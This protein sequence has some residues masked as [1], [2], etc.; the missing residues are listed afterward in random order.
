MENR[1]LCRTEH[2]DVG[3]KLG[4]LFDHTEDQ[5]VSSWLSTASA[6]RDQQNGKL[7]RVFL[8]CMSQ[9]PWLTSPPSSLRPIHTYIAAPLVGAG[10][11][12]NLTDKAP[13]LRHIRLRSSRRCIG[14][15][16]ELQSMCG[17]A[18]ILE[19]TFIVMKRACAKGGV[20][21][22]VSDHGLLNWSHPSCRATPG[23]QS[24]W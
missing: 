24:R 7:L 18:F 14:T 8:L 4:G 20:S 10:N 12:G 21:T 17:P 22:N 16:L 6:G 3:R 15:A 1:F 2:F 11:A 5:K 19:P 13:T 9:W 23:S